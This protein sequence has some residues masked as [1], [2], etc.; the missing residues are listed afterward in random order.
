MVYWHLQVDKQKP[1]RLHVAINSLL[2]T[3]VNARLFKRLNIAWT[4]NAWKCDKTYV[5]Q[6]LTEYRLGDNLTNV[7][8]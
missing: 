8:R 6:V 1:I 3:Y 5:L 4:T 2:R 7:E